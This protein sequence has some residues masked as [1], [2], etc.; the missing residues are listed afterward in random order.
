[1]EGQL[2]EGKSEYHKR[3]VQYSS[4]DKTL[5]GNV[6]PRTIRTPSG[7]EHTSELHHH[8]RWDKGLKVREN[9]GK[10]ISM[11]TAA[12]ALIASQPTLWPH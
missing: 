12:S 10:Q 3:I 4:E 8:S 6:S 7:Y 11:V 1:M 9:G 2:N 5:L